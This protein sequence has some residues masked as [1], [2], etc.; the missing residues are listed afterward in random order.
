MR[1]GGVIK[2]GEEVWPKAV[3]RCDLRRWGGVT[4]GGEEVWPKAVRRCDQKWWGGVT[5]GGEELWPKVM[6]RCDQVGWGGVAKWGEEV[7][8]NR[9][10][11]EVQYSQG[12]V[13][14]GWARLVLY[15]L[16]KKLPPPRPPPPPPMVSLYLSRHWCKN[17]DFHRCLESGSDLSICAF[18]YYAFVPRR[19][20]FAAQQRIVIAWIPK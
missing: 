20:F 11:E 13:W 16:H 17:A 1:W 19:L 8:Q 4:K 15:V 5:K 12:G 3:R 9:W 6:R 2:S 18:R 10:G 14:P 7:W